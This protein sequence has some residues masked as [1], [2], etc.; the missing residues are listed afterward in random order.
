MSLWDAVGSAAGAAVGGLFNSKA[1]SKSNKAYKKAL[2][3]L[4]RGKAAATAE[5]GGLVAEARPGFQHVKEQIAYDGRLTPAQQMSLDRLRR[6]TLNQLGKSGLRGSG[7]TVT[8]ALRDVESDFV[9]D[10]IDSNQRRADTAA[11]SLGSVY[12]QGRSGIANA[13]LGSASGMA[14]LQVDKG[15]N[16][17]NAM[18]AQGSLAGQALGDI[19]GYATSSQKDRDSKY[20][21]RLSALDDYLSQI[22]GGGSI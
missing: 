2:E 13:H 15:A 17:A 6:T 19:I 1:S 10:A 12:A 11:A 18:T 21:D 3:E 9:G 22:V 5:L 14:Q 4:R 16:A 7:R 8:A 20:S